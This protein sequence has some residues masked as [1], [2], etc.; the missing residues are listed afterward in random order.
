MEEATTTRLH[1]LQAGKTFQG[2]GGLCQT[3]TQAHPALGGLGAK[4]RSGGKPP[5]RRAGLCPDRIALRCGPKETTMGEPLIRSERAGDGIAVLT[6]DDPPANTYS[7]EM[8]RQ[9]D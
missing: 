8:M 7:Y 3:E 4:S 1:F 9:L 5:V 6:L 2:T